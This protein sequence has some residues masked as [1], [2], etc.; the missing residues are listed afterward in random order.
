MMVG[1]FFGLGTLLSAVGFLLAG[2]AA[3]TSGLWDGWR[4][5]A[6]LVTGIWTTALLGLSFTKALPGSVAIYG[7]CLLAMC[8][9]LYTQPAPVP[10]EPNRFHRPG[11]GPRRW[12]EP[13]PLT[14]G[15][16][17]V[18]SMGSPDQLPMVGPEAIHTSN[19]DG[20]GNYG[21]RCVGGT[22]P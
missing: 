13:G 8:W 2:K 5:Y 7:L 4:R 14:K 19:C 3:L 15:E 16:P 22:P 21:R 11:A 20:W 18:C 17:C 1:S 10:G 6:L 9:A 12:A